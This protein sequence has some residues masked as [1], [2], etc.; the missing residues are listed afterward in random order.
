MC[1]SSLTLPADSDVSEGKIEGREQQ[2]EQ[3][4]GEEVGGGGEGRKVKQTSWSQEHLLALR[5]ESERSLTNRNLT[6]SPSTG[7]TKY[8]TGTDSLLQI[9]SN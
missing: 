5:K 8:L 7:L 9:Q 3:E 6:K 4:G 1:L 2:V